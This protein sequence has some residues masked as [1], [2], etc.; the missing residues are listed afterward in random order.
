TPRSIPGRGRDE[1]CDDAPSTMLR[2]VPLPRFAGAGDRRR[3]WRGRLRQSGDAPVTV[4]TNTTAL[5]T[6]QWLL[7]ERPA[8]RMQARLGRAYNSWLRFSANRLALIGLCIIL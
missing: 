6:R 8:S 2:M 3:R 5:T 7:A 4:A 1:D